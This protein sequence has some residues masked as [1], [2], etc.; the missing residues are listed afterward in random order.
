MLLQRVMDGAGN[1][2]AR[3]ALRLA[4]RGGAEVLNR[5]DIGQIRAGF[6]ADLA[7]FDRRAIE[8][9]GTQTDPLAA[10]I[11]CGP[12]K[13]RHVLINGRFVVRDWHLTSMEMHDLLT[14]HDR[15]ARDLLTR[16]GR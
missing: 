12:V 11:F 13:P 10:L 1:L 5:D 14:R 4:T 9:S 3:E 15:A 7:I 6:S 16:A 8:F 2:S